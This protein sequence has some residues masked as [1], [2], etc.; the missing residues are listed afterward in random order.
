MS[1]PSRARF[2]SAI[3]VCGGLLA[4]AGCGEDQ[5]NE[6]GVKPPVATLP[7]DVN[8][9]VIPNGVIDEDPGDEGSDQDGY[10]FSPESGYYP[11]DDGAPP[12]SGPTGETPPGGGLDDGDPGSS[13]P[14]DPNDPGG[15]GEGGSATPL[16]FTQTFLGAD[17]DTPQILL[18]VDK[19][20]SMDDEAVGYPGTKWSG[21]VSA[22]S[23]V[24][25]ALD[26]AIEFGLMLYPSGDAD[27][28]VCREGDVRVDVGTSRGADIVSVLA[29]AAPG[30][31]T[32]TAATL[33]SALAALSPSAQDKPTAI[34]LATD[35]GPN[36]N[37]GLNP[38]SCRCV[39]PAGCDDSRNC[40]DDAHS[41]AAAQELTSQG[42]PVFVVGIP[43]SENFTD[44]LNGLSD[45]GGTSRAGAQGYY[46]A[47]DSTALASAVEDIAVRVGSCRFDL[48]HPVNAVDEVTVTVLGA[49]VPYNPSRQVG[50]D[51]VDRDTVE[52][53]GSTCTQL[54]NSPVPVT[55]EYCWVPET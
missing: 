55:I 7:T 18:V 21:A 24:V 23:D 13:D 5:A 11:C 49:V 14:S 36:C 3:L 51:L 53:F 45:A 37:P 41:I 32:P 34:I 38:Q 9:E 30:G 26:D 2:V 35:G 43:G 10:C 28:N 22:L 47:N 46:Q 1:R 48:E 33:R 6:Q 20:G 27:N 12:G 8:G 17:N 31:G 54:L 40:L 29:A 52:L 42:I 16:C 50:W 15:D 4:L 25:T 44:V 39:D 19:S